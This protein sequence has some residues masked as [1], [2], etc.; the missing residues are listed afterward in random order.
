MPK[1]SLHRPLRILCGDAADGLANRSL[2]GLETTDS[3]RL[4]L[5]NIAM[6]FDNTFAPVGGRKHSKMI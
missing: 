6:Y 1:N 4:F 2:T 3:D 5:R